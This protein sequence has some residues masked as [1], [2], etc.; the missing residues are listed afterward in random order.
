MSEPRSA[1]D[2]LK[3][4]LRLLRA[5]WRAGSALDQS[6]FAEV[7]AMAAVNPYATGSQLKALADLPEPYSSQCAAVFMACPALP[8]K[9][10]RQL[11]EF[12]D[13]FRSQ[14]LAALMSHP[15]LAIDDLRV[16][17][18]F[19]DPYRTQCL[20]M[21]NS[22][23]TIEVRKLAE[24][25]ALDEPF[26][27][28]CLAAIATDP[29]VDARALRA[30]GDLKEPYRTLGLGL[31]VTSGKL[32][33]PPRGAGI[34]PS[35]AAPPAPGVP[36]PEIDAARV[37][38]FGRH[39]PEVP[40][41]ADIFFRDLLG[42]A[43]PV[44]DDER[45]LRETLDW[46]IRS[47]D[48][49]GTGGFAASYAFAHGWL[50]PYPETTGYIIPTFWDAY[51][52]LHDDRYRDAAVRG[53]DWEISI[54]LDSGAIQAGYL[55]PD[56]QGFW[57][58]DTPVPAA[59]NTG[60]VV[61]GWNRTFEETKDRKYLDAAVRACEFLVQCVDEVGVFRQGLSPGPKNPTR[62]YYTRVAWSMCWT[63]QLA[64]R[65]EFGA[66]ARRHLDWVVKHQHADGWF[67]FA[68]FQD[69]EK[70]LTHTM[71]YTAEGLLQAGMLTGVDA[72]VQASERHARA[73]MESCERRGFFLPGFFSTGWKSNESFSCMPGNAQFAA[74][75][76]AHARRLRDLPMA[77]TGLK[78]VDWIKARQALDNPEPAV[79]G[80]VPGAWPVDGGYSVFCMVNWAAKY[81]A[82][83]LIEARRVKRELVDAR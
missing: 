6:R 46:L 61:L 30:M 33:V 14:C 2:V 20:G 1:V 68:S 83:A 53:A 40:G 55:G 44:F 32:G 71:A 49:T 56:P 29:S 7:V 78:M 81:F 67:P 21:L 66:A 41:H 74:L 8:V 51:H 57:N 45:H 64:G 13:P 3:T 23:P 11:A 72:Y 70:P 15:G 27:T 26:R 75:W 76:L 35:P 50:P 79:R 28:R 12:D 34:P 65:P 58:F 80:G 82:D 48:V 73:A 59:F 42:A 38:E 60:Q 22:V 36:V 19:A 25:Q 52:E 31:A 16:V 4:R 63:S 62:S 47:R 17:Y 43:E 77:N 5:A 69:D 39:R 54:Q 18:A 10:V 9:T 24:V 37:A